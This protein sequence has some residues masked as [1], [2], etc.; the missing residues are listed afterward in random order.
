M[1]RKDIDIQR[2]ISKVQDTDL[3]YRELGDL[4]LDS[5]DNQEDEEI[6]ERILIAI[7]DFGITDKQI[8]MLL[9]GI[10]KHMGDHRRSFR[11]NGLLITSCI[12][13]Y[14]GFGIEEFVNFKRY[15]EIIPDDLKGEKKTEESPIEECIKLPTKNKV[16][17]LKQAID[18]LKMKDVD[19]FEE[20]FD[21]LE[22]LI[23]KSSERTLKQAD[24][25]LKVIVNTEFDSFK[26]I[27][28]LALLIHRNES[29]VEVVIEEIFVSN[30]SVK[31]KVDLI[32][33]LLLYAQRS[34]NCKY[35]SILL[36]LERKKKDS[37]L[38]NVTE[39]YLKIL[40]DELKKLM[41]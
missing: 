41:V 2:L 35:Q 4:F 33:S 17:Y 7:R 25:F 22:F 16:K 19:R 10:R 26:K 24:E 29:L 39:R 30:H 8:T 18:I 37:E 15:Q 5:K 27:E 31:D 9:E 21:N 23:I 3:M 12:F 6:T 1:I 40:E 14:R 11:E 13:K 38:H 36:A 20:I 32:I 34:P 28:A